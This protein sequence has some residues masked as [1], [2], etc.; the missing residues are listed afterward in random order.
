MRRLALVWLVPATMAAV[1]RADLAEVRAEP[2]PEK[3]A[4]AAL[5]F[6]EDALRQARA[7]Y[8]SGEAQKSAQLLGQVRESVELADE[9]LKKSGKKPGKSPRP[10][11]E[12]EQKTR[13]L[14]RRLKDFKGEMS[15]DDRAALEPVESKIQQIHD[16]LLIGILEKRK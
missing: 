14:L 8:G 11:K 7:A 16:D 13:D 1:L 5:D 6:A 12:A 4:R 15:V 10:F 3:R 9:S 2:H